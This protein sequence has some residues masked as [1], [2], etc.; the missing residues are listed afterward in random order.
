MIG[1]HLCWDLVHLAGIPIPGYTSKPGFLWQQSICWGFILLSGFCAALGHHGKRR[2]IVVFCSGLLVTGVT[3][4]FIPDTR[5]LFGILTF[6][7]SAMIISDCFRRYLE[8]IPSFV[9]W[10][11]FFLLFLISFPINKGYLLCEKYPVF[12]PHG[13][14]RNL[15]FTYLGY[16]C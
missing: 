10:I 12:L 5:V 16:I 13:W 8:R 1:Y 7:G 3:F 4:F 6:L 14:Y 9:G 15:F 2:G 11:V